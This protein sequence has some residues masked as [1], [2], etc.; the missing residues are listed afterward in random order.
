MESSKITPVKRKFIKM[1][2]GKQTINSTYK[3]LK[4]AQKKDPILKSASSPRKEA[5]GFPM[6]RI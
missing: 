4:T 1:K 5:A 6:L 3:R 2:N